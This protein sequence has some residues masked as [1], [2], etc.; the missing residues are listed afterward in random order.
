MNSPQ[1]ES[2]QKIRKV[3]IS[4]QAML[5][6]LL[7]RVVQGHFDKAKALAD[8]LPIEVAGLQGLVDELP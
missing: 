5:D 8:K 6:M 7:L 3:V 1:E 2:N 4:V